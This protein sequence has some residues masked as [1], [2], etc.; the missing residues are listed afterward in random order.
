M[1]IYIAIPPESW[2]DKITDRAVIKGY[3]VDW[4]REAIER[5]KSD[6][7]FFPYFR[8]ISE[9]HIK[10]G[11]SHKMSFTWGTKKQ[12]SHRHRTASFNVPTTNPVSNLYESFHGNP[13]KDI[14]KVYYEAPKGV[15]IKIG[16]LSQINYVP[17]V[18]SE[19]AGQEFFHKAGDTGEKVLKSNL[20]LC[21]D[22]NGKNLY[23]VRDTKSNR[24]YFSSRGIIG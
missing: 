4:V 15:L 14:R 19:K 23:L 11:G 17:E 5:A 1:R 12:W 16:R 2:G 3:N 24:P 20:I 8:K 21:T 13:P 18:P 9:Y 6:P 7:F 10:L 22:K